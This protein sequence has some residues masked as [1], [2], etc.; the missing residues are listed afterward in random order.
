M[1]SVVFAGLVLPEGI[2]IAIGFGLASKR[3]RATR[4]CA[5]SGSTRSHHH[6]DRHR[7]RAE[8]VVLQN[9][10]AGVRLARRKPAGLTVTASWNGM[11]LVTVKVGWLTLRNDPPVVEAFT[12]S[13]VKVL[14]DTVRNCVTL[15]VA[16]A[17]C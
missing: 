13:E 2:E 5:R 4:A 9:H 11:E 10:I 15:C 8:V 14:V 1:F 12:V 6:R 7:H 16:P 17:E 3:T